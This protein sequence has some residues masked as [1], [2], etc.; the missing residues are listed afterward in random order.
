MQFESHGR[1]KK[2]L[3]AVDELRRELEAEDAQMEGEEEYEEVSE[4]EATGEV[5]ALQCGCV[6]LMA[7]HR[8]GN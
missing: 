3:K 7:V 1:S 4:P 2:H 8:R 5:C 6:W